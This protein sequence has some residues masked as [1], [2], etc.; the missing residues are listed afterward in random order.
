M[1]VCAEKRETT[2]GCETAAGFTHRAT[3][4]DSVSFRRCVGWNEVQRGGW[5]T[6]GRVVVVVGWWIVGDDLQKKNAKPP[7]TN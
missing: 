1:Q 2:G 7:E 3:V 6:V 5:S 4:S